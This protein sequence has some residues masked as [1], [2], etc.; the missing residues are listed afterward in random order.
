MIE[1]EMS[2]EEAEQI[3]S[4]FDSPAQYLAFVYAKQG[5]EPALRAVLDYVQN[6]SEEPRF[7]EELVEHADEIAESGRPALMFTFLCCRHC[8]RP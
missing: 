6:H 7:R 5:G 3:A 1:R 8:W 4:Q 2:D